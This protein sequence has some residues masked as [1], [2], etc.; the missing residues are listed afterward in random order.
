MS[1]AAGSLNLLAEIA[2]SI[3]DYAASIGKRAAPSLKYIA[4]IG[5]YVNQDTV[6]AARLMAGCVATLSEISFDF[7]MYLIDLI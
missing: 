1:I 5:K 6:I 3:C 4:N 7:L 2:S